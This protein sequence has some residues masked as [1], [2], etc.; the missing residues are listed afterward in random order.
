MKIVFKW[1]P[2]F[3]H[4]RV[5]VDRIFVGIIRPEYTSGWAFVHITNRN[6]VLTTARWENVHDVVEKKIT[7]L[8]VAA[9]LKS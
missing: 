2:N 7:A 3:K 9:R 6:A 1:M 8:N 5:I 4:H